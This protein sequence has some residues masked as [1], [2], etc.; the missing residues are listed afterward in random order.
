V[1]GAD[2]FDAR[3][4]AKDEVHHLLDWRKCTT[5]RHVSEM[6]RKTL[7]RSRG[8]GI[9]TVSQHHGF[10]LDQTAGAAD[11]RRCHRYNQVHIGAVEVLEHSRDIG[12]LGLRVGAADFKIFSLFKP[13]IAQPVEQTFYANL[14]ARFRREIGEADFEISAERDAQWG[15][16]C[17]SGGS[18]T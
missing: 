15:S 6:V 18:A 10:A 3:N 1:N 17:G 5:T 12:N 9:R 16:R 13:Q 4:G 11:D 8:N 7:P 2:R 14:P